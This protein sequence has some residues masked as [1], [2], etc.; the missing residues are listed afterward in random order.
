[1]TLRRI[2]LG[3]VA[4]L[5]LPVAPPA[6]A[7][8][9][10]YPIFDAHIHYSRPDWDSYTPERILSILAKAGVRRA[11]VSSTPDEGT[12]KLYEKA[13]KGIVPFLRPYRTRD[14]MGS[15]PR[16]LAVQAYVE[17]R[18]KRGIHKGIGEAHFGVS[19]VDAPVVKRFAELVAERGIFF[20][21][22][23]DDA[24]AEGMLKR[25]PNTKLLWAHAGMGASPATVQ[26]L[27]DTYP[28]LWVE[29][30][31]RTDVAPGGML[32]PGWRAVFLK[33][34]DRFMVGTDTW[35][36]SRWE[37]VASYMRDVQVWLGQLPRDVAEKI[38]WKNGERLFP[39]P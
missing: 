4:A 31:L 5:L 11:I 26:R 23:I 28:M 29:L 30:A 21:C 25:Y 16:D 3:L 9:G 27:L 33:H 34:P 24:T 20:Q 35:T 18:L 36:T 10:Q 14:D 19:D 37:I 22:H 1:M 32:D 2:A 13:P 12:L 38:A 15:W 7:Q 39:E 6:G 8:S 17:E